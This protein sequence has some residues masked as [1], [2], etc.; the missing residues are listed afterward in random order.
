M[1]G[2]LNGGLAT[3]IDLVRLT[4]NLILSLVLASVLAWYYARF[5]RALS[6]RARFA[7]TLPL[8]AVTTA[9]VFTM[10]RSSAAL[11]LG[12]VGALSI[13]RFRTAIKEPEELLYLFVA[14]AIGLGVGAEQQAA[15]VVA[16][17]VVLAYLSLRE[18]TAPRQ[19]AGNVYVD[20]ISPEGDSTFAE[21][22]ELLRRHSPS[23]NLRRIDRRDATIQATYLIPS[24][25]DSLLIAL[26]DELRDQIP[27]CEFSFVEQ[28]NTLGG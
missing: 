4:A 10:V 7:Q 3:N 12:L 23:A 8:L 1:D 27:D 28:D 21:I 22:S 14:I 9:F 24:S 26:M 15:T 5:G 11:A 19:L 13:I 25:D 18:Y 20:I 17:V 2:F 6:N 16:L